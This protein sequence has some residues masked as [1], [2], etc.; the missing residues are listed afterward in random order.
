MKSDGLILSPDYTFALTAK[1]I[2]SDYISFRD[3]WFYDEQ[4]KFNRK[5]KQTLELLL[6]F[7][8]TYLMGADSDVD[9]SKPINDGLVEIISTTDDKAFKYFSENTDEIKERAKL[10][11][12]VILSNPA[13]KYDDDI[14]NYLKSKGISSNKLLSE[15]FNLRFE[16]EFHA[17]TLDIFCQYFIEKNKNHDSKFNISPPEIVMI[18]SNRVGN[19]AGQLMHY[20]DNSSSREIPI[21]LD[22]FKLAGIKPIN[23]KLADVNSD[24]YNAFQIIVLQMENLIGTFPKVD[25]IYDVLSIKEKKRNELKNLREILQEVEQAFKLNKKYAFWKSKKLIEKASKDLRHGLSYSKVSKW[26]TYLSVPVGSIETA[27]AI[28]PIAGFTIGL[29]G[30]GSTF[31][32]NKIVKN[33]NWINICR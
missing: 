32:S 33:N 31:L 24:I 4:L 3:R 7:E 1:L 26:T 27:L 15:L 10:L 16:Q 22:E 12:P 25:T 29:L 11:K 5:K 6:L 18:H 28:P 20:L 17:E 13:L 23:K 2:E 9:F 19:F 30:S 14:R 21:I 8:K